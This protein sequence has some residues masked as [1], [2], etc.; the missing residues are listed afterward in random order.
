L[1]ARLV[2]RVIGTWRMVGTTVQHTRN[3]HNLGVRLQSTSKARQMQRILIHRAA[4]CRAVP[5]PSRSHAL[6]RLCTHICLRTH[7]D[8]HSCSLVYTC[9]HTRSRVCTLIHS[10]LECA[11]ALLAGPCRTITH[12]ARRA[13]GRLLPARVAMCATLVPLPSLPSSAASV[14]MPAATTPL[15]LL[16]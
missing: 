9:A 3:S 14:R 1:C 12:T 16:R 15:P 10:R 7:A 8:A 5:Q 6:A 2:A 13:L 4:P 11:H